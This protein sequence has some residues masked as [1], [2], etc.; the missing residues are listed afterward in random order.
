MRFSR[1]PG[2]NVVSSGV[3]D[4]ITILRS[5]AAVVCAV[6]TFNI[7]TLPK[8]HCEMIGVKDGSILDIEPFTKD[9][10]ILKVMETEKK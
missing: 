10:L 9:S 7:I 6:A 3:V 4:L 1:C 5:S 2:Q 8:S